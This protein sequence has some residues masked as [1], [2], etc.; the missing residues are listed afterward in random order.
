MKTIKFKNG[1]ILY[2]YE[3]DDLNEEIQDKTISDHID[4][5]METYAYDNKDI[6]PNLKKAYDKADEMLTPWFTGSYI[7]E[8]CKEE[9]I[10]EI[11]T[12]DYLFDEEGDML[13]ICYHTNKNKIVKVTYGTKE[14]EVELV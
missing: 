3:F 13:P 14:H 6:P 5:W 2:G 9:I 12:N 11:K 7:Y 1:Q 8:Y 10:E 4:F